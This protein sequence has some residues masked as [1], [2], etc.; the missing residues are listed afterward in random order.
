MQEK[1]WKYRDKQLKNDDIK[2]FSQKFNLPYEMAVLLLLRG[3]ADEK[4]IALYMNKGLDGIHSPFLLSDMETA[5]ERIINAINSKEKITVYGDYDVDGITATTVL[6]DFLASVG[7]EVDYYIPNR[8]SE[9]YG[10][11]ILAV[12]KIA[13]NGAKL[14]ITVDCGISSIGEI[15]FAKTQKLDVIV[16]DH[17]SCKNEIPKAVAVINPKRADSEYPFSGLA[18][19]GVAFKLVLALAKKLSLNTKDIFLKYA[20]IVAIGTIADVVPLLDENRIIADR[21][22]KIIQNT[23]NFGIKALL[24]VAGCKD[25]EIT[26]SLVAFSLAPRINAAGR[27]EKASLAVE[28]FK[29]KSYEEA[30]ELA[31]HLDSLNKM[32]RSIEQ[33]IFDDAQILAE[34]LENPLVYVLKAKGWHHGVI[35]IVASRLC[36]KFSRPCILLSDE[37]GKCKGSGRSIEGFN[38]F[39]ALSDSEEVLTAFGGHAQAAGLSIKSEDVDAFAKRINDYAKKI[40]KPEMLIPVLSVDCEINPAHI[41]LEWA[42]ALKKLEPFGCDNET[43]VFSL[44]GV[45]IL[46]QGTMGA[47]KQHL[48]MRVAKGENIFSTVG[49]GMG[50][51]SQELFQGYMADIAFTMNI[52]TYNG[53]ESVQLLIKDLKKADRNY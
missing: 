13:R 22:I 18:G 32:R 45:K 38:L 15:E 9:G 14:M 53:T 10:L 3:I 35:G 51:L 41:T 8:F 6:T 19:V 42:N 20:D 34:N 44:S 26:A 17:H 31:E 21:G 16:T 28:L 39:D 48:Y 7:A 1:L 52:N 27:M 33:K 49:F 43:P 25:K 12:N 5:C 23:Q 36:E 24:E 50:G 30:S 4:D 46:S 2:T 29:S 40:I 47:D 11:N 37:D